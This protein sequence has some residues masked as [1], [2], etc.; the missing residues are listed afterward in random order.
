ML[1]PRFVMF[2]ILAGSGRSFLQNSPCKATTST[3][4]TP[5]RILL[6]EDRTSSSD[7]ATAETAESRIAGQFKVLTCASTSCAKKRKELGQDE[8]ATFSELYVRAKN[9]LPTMTVEEST[10]LGCCKAAP[11]VGIEHEDYDGTVALD[12]MTDSEFSD[13]VFQKVCFVE[14]FDRVWQSIENAVQVLAAEEEGEHNH[15]NNDD[16]YDDEEETIG[17]QGIEV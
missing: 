5:T 2:V 15:G 4:K 11:C 8:Y 3:T 13:R 9:T 14:D 10:C 16:Y 6:S 1:G 7:I 12:G 17:N